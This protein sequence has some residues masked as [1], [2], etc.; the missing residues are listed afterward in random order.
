M[1]ASATGTTTISENC[2]PTA[3]AS[4]NPSSTMRRQF[5]RITSRGAYKRMRHRDG[6]ENCAER[7]P[8]RAHFRL[9]KPKRAGADNARRETIKSQ[10]NVSAG[11]TEKA[12]RHV[13]R[14]KLPAAGQKSDKARR[15]SQ[16]RAPD[17]FRLQRDRPQPQ[18]GG[19]DQ[20]PERRMIVHRSRRFRAR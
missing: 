4:D 2:E 20:I 3:S 6:G 14:V 17:I 16:C 10:R 8:G 15:P 12:A 9:G 18:R 19:G 11:I 13:P 7:S 5:H 1:N